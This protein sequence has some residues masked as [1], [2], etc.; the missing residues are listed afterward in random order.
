MK[1]IL[2]LRSVVVLH[3]AF[4]FPWPSLCPWITVTATS[5]LCG[6]FST[7]ILA[8]YPVFIAKDYSGKQ[9]DAFRKKKKKKADS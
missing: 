3:L 2:G 8:L 1:I 6:Y 9:R 7:G 5:V 4:L